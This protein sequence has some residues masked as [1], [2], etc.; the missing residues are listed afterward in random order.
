M[1]TSDAVARAQAETASLRTRH[2]GRFGWIRDL[3]DARDH[4]YSVSLR[5][6]Q[7]LPPSMDLRAHCPPVYDQGRIGSCTANAIAGAIQFDRRRAGQAPDFVPSRLFIYY[8]ER[9]IEHDVPLDRGAQLRD[10]IKAVARL[11]R[12]AEKHYGHPQDV[13]WALDQHLPPGE[14]VV[15][16]QSRPETVWSRRRATPIASPTGMESIVSTLLSPLARTRKEE[17]AE[18]TH[19]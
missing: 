12:R 10:G 13:E 5:T 15:L 7:S 19:A 17:G 2:I 4:G 18:Q 14:N 16:L 8:N 11:A 9:V 1:T 3:P 6:L